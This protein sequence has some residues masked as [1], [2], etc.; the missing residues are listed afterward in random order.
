MDL[1]VKA[2]L[3]LRVADGGLRMSGPVEVVKGK[4]EPIPGRIFQVERGRITFPGAGVAAGQLDV[5]ARYDNPAAVVTVTIGGLVSKP[6]I[7]LS[8]RPAMDDAAI[9]MLIATGR[10]EIKANTSA[11]SSVSGKGSET[12]GK[13]GTDA[14]MS[15][16]FQ[17]LVSDKLPV[18]QVSL[19]SSTL[20][21][22]KYLTDTIFVGY[23]RRWDAKR[24]QGENENEVKAELRL[25]PRWNFELRYGD[26]QSGDA[27]LI[28]SKDYC[29]PPRRAGGGAAVARRSARPIHQARA[30]QS[31]VRTTSAGFTRV[32][33]NQGSQ[34]RARSSNSRWKSATA[35]AESTPKSQPGAAAR[36]PARKP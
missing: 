10:T 28:W 35:A 9:A 29:G 5:V 17:G 11:I 25:T 7:Q 1:E 30:S 24:D 6:S 16:A 14:A 26:A 21:A 27:S 8:S 18:D 12:E 23:M 13:E 33:M 3:V 31:A 19:D 15:L 20:R 2:D 32:S 22:G 36:A 34:R 4:V